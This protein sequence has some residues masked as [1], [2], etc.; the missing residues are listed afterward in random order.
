MGKIIREKHHRLEEEF[1]RGC[2]VV[3]FTACVK[4]RV[5]FFTVEDRFRNCEVFLLKALKEFESEAEV[6]LFMPDHAHLLL[7]GEN[8]TSDV[9]KTIKSF[10]QKSGFWLYQNHP[11]VHWQKD[12]YDHILRKEKEV[13]KHI[14]YILYNPVRAGLVEDWGEY[15]FK[16]STIHNLN[17]WN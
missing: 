2:K 1:Y 16:G 9:L 4:D 3:S 8:E 10:K 13:A 11:S 5:S 17:E 15:P 6:Y 12:F 14:R 7:R